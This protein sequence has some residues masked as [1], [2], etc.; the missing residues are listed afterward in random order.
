MKTTL[1]KTCAKTIALKSEWWNFALLERCDL[2]RIF[3]CNVYENQE[4][5]EICEMSFESSL[6]IVNRAAV[7][8]DGKAK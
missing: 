4:T 2:R 6:Q 3:K 1:K 7:N 8:D 5:T